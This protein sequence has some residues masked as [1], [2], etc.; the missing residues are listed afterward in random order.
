MK[1]TTKMS[2]IAGYLEKMYRE[3]NTDSFNGMLEMP[4]IT[5]QST[6]GAYGH[7]TTRKTWK[8][9][10]ET[11]YELNISAD[12]LTRPIENVVATLIHEMVHI[13]H[14]M[15]DIQDCS[16][17]GSYHN[18]KFRDE[19]VKHM[20]HIDKDER[21][22]W[23]ITSPTDELLEYI[24]DKGWGEILTGK[25]PL[26]GL[27]WGAG[28]GSAGRTGTDRGG[29]AEDPDKR[30]KGNSRRYQC[31]KCKAIVRTTKDLH[32][33]CGDCQADFELTN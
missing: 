22:G 12:W 21:Y 7:V 32:I 6:P 25:N 23:T 15:N 29:D 17:G 24:M 31:P 11:A 26:L 9:K 1:E 19:A 2:R 18:K 28:S 14:L 4:I 27:F 3:I 10:D 16:R 30:R 5:I 8:R 33:I 13:Y 20:L